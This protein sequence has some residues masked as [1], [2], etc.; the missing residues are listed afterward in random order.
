MKSEIEEEEQ[1]QIM[2]ENRIDNFFP[3][4]VYTRPCT[5]TRTHTRARGQQPAHPTTP[6]NGIAV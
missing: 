1:Q 3:D 6:R 4:V 2:E 5:H